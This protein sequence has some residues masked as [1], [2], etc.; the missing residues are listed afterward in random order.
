MERLQARETAA[1]F[2]LCLV[3]PLSYCRYLMFILDVEFLST[4]S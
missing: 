2:S 4:D 1:G 3:L